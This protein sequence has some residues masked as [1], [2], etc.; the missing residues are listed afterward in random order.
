[1]ACC[2]PNSTLCKIW[3]ATYRQARKLKWKFYATENYCNLKPSP[4]PN[5]ASRPKPSHPK[6]T[7]PEIKKGSDCSLFCNQN[8]YRLQSLMRYSAERACAS[9]CSLRA[10]T[11]ATLDNVEAP[12]AEHII[13]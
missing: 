12:C 4:V 13:T 11:E 5:H 9:S 2:S 8:F 6:C 7:S 10:N 1:M 3:L